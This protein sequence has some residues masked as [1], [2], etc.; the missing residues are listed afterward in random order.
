MVHLFNSCWKLLLGT[1][2]LYPY[3]SEANS[4]ILN[5]LT[6]FIYLMDKTEVFPSLA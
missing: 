6:A 5:E 4:S 1:W 2:D 3:C